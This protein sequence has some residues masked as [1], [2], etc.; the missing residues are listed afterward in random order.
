MKTRILLSAL[1]FL[2]V[3]A[4]SAFVAWCGGYNFDKRN[5]DVACWVCATGTIAVWLGGMVFIFTE[6]KNGSGHTP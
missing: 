5:P 4:L 1:A 2:A 3:C 6:P